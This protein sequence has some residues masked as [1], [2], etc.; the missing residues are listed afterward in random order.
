M[1]TYTPRIV[2]FFQLYLRQSLY[3]SSLFSGS[4]RDG[5]GDRVHL[6]V[7]DP[8]VTPEALDEALGSLYR[9]EINVEPAKVGN[10]RHP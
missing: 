1:N 10:R 5:C 4:W 7:A 9:D 3:F 2:L 6:D 8:N